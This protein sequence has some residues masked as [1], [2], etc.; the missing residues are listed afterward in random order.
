MNH[1][2][3]RNRRRFVK[4]ALT[5]AGAMACTWGMPPAHAT[6]PGRAL[7]GFQVLPSWIQLLST[8]LTELRGDYEPDLGTR[9][10]VVPGAAG[11]L[12]L[13]TIRRS[14]RDGATVLISPSSVLTMTP[15]VQGARADPADEVLPIAAIGTIPFGFIVG[16][17]VPARIGTLSEYLAWVRTN[18][19]ANSYGVPGLGT[20]PHY[21]GT[22]MSRLADLSLRAVGYKGSLALAEDV[23][24]GSIP[25]GLTVVLGHEDSVRYPQLRLLAV[26]GSRR[27]AELPH[28]PTLRESG[29]AETFP[30]E[31]LGFFLPNGT[32]EAKIQQLT[33]AIRAALQTSAVMAAMTAAVIDPMAAANE[34]YAATISNERSSW[35]VLVRPQA[36]P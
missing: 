1:E 33:A 9:A 35:R 26:A 25:A 11:M 17:A 12:A 27:L 3:E 34:S 28:V 8:I 22:E 14:P 6:M 31:S 5:V 30:G 16:P 21:V 24:N 19:A 13:E 2:Q 15:A 18:P 36:R 4:T 20:A 23:A 29:F 7:I 32:P 10:I